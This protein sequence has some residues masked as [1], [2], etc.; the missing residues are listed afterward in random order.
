MLTARRAFWFLWSSLLLLKLGVAAQLPLFGDE[1]WYWLESRH[2]AWAYSDLPA[3]TAWV[4]RLGTWVAGDT[5]FGVRWP[6]VLLGMLLPWLV[7]R[8][9][10]RWFGA[11]T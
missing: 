5:W 11:E 2:P 4:I 9:S 3:M 7:M 6:F 8:F 10:A 1:A